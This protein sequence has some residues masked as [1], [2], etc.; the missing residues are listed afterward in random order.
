MPF[1]LIHRTDHEG[2]YIDVRI[3]DGEQA[4]F[5]EVIWT[6]GIWSGEG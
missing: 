4:L 6:Q 5:E 2:A 1:R 3:P